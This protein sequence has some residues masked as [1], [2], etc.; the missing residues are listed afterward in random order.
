MS[1]KTGVRIVSALLV[2]AT[3]GVMGLGAFL[4]SGKVIQND[5]LPSSFAEPFDYDNGTYQDYIAWS[6]RRLRTARLEAPAE[7]VLANLLPFELEPDADCPVDAQGRVQNGIVLVHG[8]IASPWSM[9][10]I[11]EYFQSRC[12]HVLGILMHGH[13]SRVGDMLESTWQDWHQDVQFAARILGQKAGQVSLSGHSVGGTLA[14]LEAARNPDID[15]LILFAPALAV[16]GASGYARPISWLGRLFP[17]AAW[18]ELEPEEG[19]YRYESFPFTAAAE[20]WDL[21]QET[22]RALTATPL[23]IPVFTVASAQDTTVLVQATFDFMQALPDPR[24]F[25]LLY[26][27]FDLPPYSRARIVNSSLP[28]QGILS[29]GH[30]GLMTPPEHPHY[31]VNGNYHY[32]GQYFGQDNDNF[33]RCKAGESDFYGEGTEANLA[34]GVIE[35]ITF[36]PFYDDMLEEIDFFIQQINMD[37]RGVPLQR[38]IPGANPLNIEN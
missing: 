21:I 11:G 38:D 9:K 27:Q 14:I 33:A 22:N 12:F 8:L 15:S 34:R 1:M 31:G 28:E 37:Q 36:N 17:G 10:H 25:T 5:Q 19:I 24:S 6:E 4:S 32:C 3:L 18:F 29:L 13:G 30:L 2:L 20:T 23:G 26:S 16:D 7:E 35:R